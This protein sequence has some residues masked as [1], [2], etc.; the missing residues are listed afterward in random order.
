[1]EFMDFTWNS[2]SSAGVHGFQVE[3][4]VDR[5][6]AIISPGVTL[7]ERVNARTHTCEVTGSNLVI[8]YTKLNFVDYW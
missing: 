3:F 6:Q 8:E 5:C 2:W 7:T 4:F 1:M